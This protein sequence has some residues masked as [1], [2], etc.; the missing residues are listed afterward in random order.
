MRILNLRSA[1]VA[2]VLFLTATAFAPAPAAIAPSDLKQT[3]AAQVDP[4]CEMW[5]QCVGQCPTVDVNEWEACK[6]TCDAVYPCILG[7]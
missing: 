1:A 5:V 2:S 7:E 6:A 4:L 3:I